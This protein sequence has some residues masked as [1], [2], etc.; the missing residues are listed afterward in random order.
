MSAVPFSFVALREMVQGKFNDVG[1]AAVVGVGVRAVGQQTNQAPQGAGRVVFVPSSASYS[2][3]RSYDTESRSIATMPLLIDVHV[4]DQALAATNDEAAQID[5]ALAL[6]DAT[7]S[8]LRSIAVGMMR[9]TGAV[10]VDS[11]VERTKGKALVCT[12]EVLRQVIE[13]PWINYPRDGVDPPDAPARADI[14]TYLVMPSGDIP[15]C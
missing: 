14:T 4:W 13:E 12:M 10:W 3:P 15:A 9:F 7:M 1:V 11:P 5:A 2:S 8:A 6:H